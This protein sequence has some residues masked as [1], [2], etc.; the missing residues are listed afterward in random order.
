M[1][2]VLEKFYFIISRVSTKFDVILSAFSPS[3]GNFQFG[4][5]SIIF[6]KKFWFWVPWK[7]LIVRVIFLSWLVKIWRPKIPQIIQFPW[8]HS[9]RGKVVFFSLL[10]SNNCYP[11]LTLVSFIPKQE[12][13]YSSPSLIFSSSSSFNLAKGRSI[14]SIQTRHLLLLFIL[15][16]YTPLRKISLILASLISPLFSFVSAKCVSLYSSLLVVF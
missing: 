13:N 8:L 16:F 10:F 6:Q 3:N 7:D 11:A 9:N 1:G 4:R 5:K 12:E 14:S 2:L 15:S